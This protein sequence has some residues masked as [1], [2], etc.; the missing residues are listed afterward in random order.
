MENKA[1]QAV[2]NALQLS[3]LYLIFGM[4]WIYFSDQLVGWFSVQADQILVW[5]T[6]KGFFF[7]GVTALLLYLL[8][9]RILHERHIEYMTHL[10]EH[11]EAELR[12]KKQ[13]TLLKELVNSLPD[14]VYV[15]DLEGRYLVFNHMAGVITEVDEKEAIGKTDYELFTPEMAN[16]FIEKNRP[17]LEN[18]Q[19]YEHES[20]IT[21]ADGSQ[22]NILASK[23]PL[24]NE[25]GKMF[26]VFGITRDI[27]KDKMIQKR[28]EQQNSLLTSLIDSSRDAIV[29][30]G[31]DRRYIVFNKGASNFSGVPT[32]EAIGKTADEIFPLSTANIINRIDDNLLESDSFIE[33]EETMLMPNGETYIYWVTKGLLKTDQG[34]IFGIFGMYRDITTEKSHEKIITDEKERF[35]FM[36]HHDP[37]TGLPNRLSLVEILQKQ[38]EKAPIEPFI[39]MFIDLDGFKEINDSFG[40]NFGDQMLILFSQLLRDL[41]PKETLIIRTGGDEFVAVIESSEK[42]TVQKHLNRL[43]QILNN[44]FI[45]EQIEVFI[46][47]SIGISVFPDDALNYEELLQKADAAMYKAKNSGR[48]TYSFY[49]DGL[50]QEVLERTTLASNLKKAISNNNLT[51]YYQPQVD[52]TS[53]KINGAEALVRWFSS[54]GAIP[55][56]QFI[57]IAEER[58]LILELGAFVLHEGFLNAA[59]W[60]NEGML[61]GRV[62]I[63]V[64]AKQLIH[65]TFLAE[66]ETILGKTRCNPEWI[67]IE[68][69]ESSI[70]EYPEKII[71]LLGVIKSKGFK[72]SIDD[73]GTGYSSL[74]YLKHLPVD[75]LK[76]DISFIRN[77]TKEPKNQTIVRTIVA[78]AQGLG[79]TTLAEGVESADELEFLRGC[80]VDFIQGYYYY[81]PMDVQSVES[82]FYKTN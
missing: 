26:A 48:N 65:P 62:A 67:E 15:K 10:D 80:G 52:L 27:T 68:I 76:I 58:G 70:L 38:T 44:P 9:Y 20:V 61:S 42:Y 54:E 32:K 78:L 47:A 59:R 82:L 41:F 33:H 57:P 73:F 34:E 66:L 40:H 50:T 71:S 60:A 28:L 19:I 2:K 72:I 63:N 37:L 13:E 56:S 3:V 36:A 77:I 8:S 46:T 24:F 30:K 64:S 43:I 23:G 14:S 31:L 81:K 45:I 53:E 7:V 69:T 18:A 39:L 16:I 6:Y 25:E 21:T 12:I 51:L 55:P 1:P 29:V 11:K 49:N 4:I 75:K 74:S 17:V 79:M 5:Q 35:D 22:K